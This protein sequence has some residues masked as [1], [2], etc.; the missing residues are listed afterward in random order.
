M[1]YCENLDRG[2]SEWHLYHASHC[3][4]STPRKSGSGAGQSVWRRCEPAAARTVAE[5][6]VLLHVSRLPLLLLRNSHC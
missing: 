2:L 4:S 1:G 5:L 3:F 6:T